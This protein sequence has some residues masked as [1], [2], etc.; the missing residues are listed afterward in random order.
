M[1]RILIFLLFLPSSCTL[2]SLG[3]QADIVA[4]VNKYQ[5]RSSDIALLI[6]S[7]LQNEDSLS[8]LRQY[9]N[10]WI[11]AHL[12]E[13]KAQKELPKEVK[14]VSQALEEYRRSLLVFLYEKSYVET[15]IDTAITLEEMM[16]TYKD[17]EPLFTLSEPIVKVRYIKIAISSPYLS[18]VRSLYCTRSTEETYQLEQMAYHSAEKYDTYNDQWISALHLSRDLPISTE[19]V[20]RSMYRGSSLE[21]QDNTFAY[22]VAFLD[23][24]QA[25]SMAP[26]EYEEATIRNIIL[27]R[28]KQVLLKNLEKE[29]WEEGRNS[30]QFNVYLNDNE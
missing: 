10:T 13:L 19:E 9:V 26:L 22:F 25:G 5:L 29:V 2:F 12:I 21:Y 1:Y 24:T 11:L 23:I 18:K 7:G 6:P 28:R 14:D 8:M 27:G 15:R 20:V 30:K 16:K 17:N 4:E 3:N